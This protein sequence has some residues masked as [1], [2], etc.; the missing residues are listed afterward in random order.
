MPVIG[1]SSV[2]P[3]FNAVGPS[4]PTG[5]TVAGPTGNTGATGATGNTGATGIHVVSTSKNFPYLNLNLSDGSVV[6]IKGVAGITGA[7]GTVNGVN[8]GDGINVFSRVG[9]GVTGATF[10]I[11]LCF[12]EQPCNQIC[13]LSS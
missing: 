13:T 5:A 3:D 11:C 8:L 9:N 4:G 2:T 12:S 10:K 6:Q 7:T 1:S